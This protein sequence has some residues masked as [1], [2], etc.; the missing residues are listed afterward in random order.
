[1]DSF[2]NHRKQWTLYRAASLAPFVGLFGTTYG[3]IR[4]FQNLDTRAPIDPIAPGIL[5]AIV[6]GFEVTLVF[7]L[8]LTVWRLFFNK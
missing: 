5:D 3:I 7:L 8:L 6:A 1:M 2:D 4:A